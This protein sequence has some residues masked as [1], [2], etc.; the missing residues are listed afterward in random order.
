MDLLT[1]ITGWDF[2]QACRRIE[3]HLGISSTGPGAPA[4]AR[5]P[6]AAKAKPKGRPHRIPEIPPAGTRQRG[7][8]HDC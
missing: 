4:P 5:S 2:K 7:L 8:S 6:A 1:R 3:Q